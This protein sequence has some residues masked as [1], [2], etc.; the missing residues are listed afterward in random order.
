MVHVLSIQIGSVREIDPAGQGQWW[1]QPWRSGFL[2]E[3]KDGLQKLGPT[4]FEG[5]EQ[6]DRQNHG[7]PD[8]AICVYAAEHYSYWQSALSLAE[9]PWGAFGE[10]LT[11]R[12]LLETEICLGD[13]Y[14]VGTAVVQISQPRQPCWKLARRWRVQD[15]AVQVEQTGRTG[16]YFRVLQEGSV[17]AGAAFT[18]RERPHPEWTVDR[19]NQIMHHLKND[20]D[21]ARR[22]AQCPALSA[23]WVRTLTHRAENQGPGASTAQRQAGPNRKGLA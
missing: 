12:G 18:L 10:N 22:L 16:W 3:P 21:A 4:G 1:D 5:D 2:K 20:R 13:V 11:T 6:A 9:M 19:A 23:S 7:G 17:A 15:L 14:A 8:K